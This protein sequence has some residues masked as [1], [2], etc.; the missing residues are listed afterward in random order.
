MHV[1]CT[2]MHMICNH[3]VDYAYVLWDMQCLMHMPT[4]SPDS[5][6]ARYAYVFEICMCKKK[7]VHMNPNIC[8]LLYYSLGISIFSPPV[9]LYF[10]CIYIPI[11][12]TV[13]GIV[14]HKPFENM[15]IISEI[16]HILSSSYAYATT[17][18]A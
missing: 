17:D 9:I 2:N 12:S 15:H 3:F 7:L 18:Y 10:I 5:D 14:M 8:I 11:L 13:I 6:M 16:V 4:T 1:I